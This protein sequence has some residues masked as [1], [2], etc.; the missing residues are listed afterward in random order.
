MDR[1]RFIALILR[2]PNDHPQVKKRMDIC[3]QV[4]E[5]KIDVEDI[6]I[7]GDSLLAKMFSTIYLGDFT[8]YHLA[9]RERIDPTPVEVIEWLKK[10][11]V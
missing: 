9:L 6:Q 5:K 11:L 7:K 8:S 2:D 10:Q 4:M 1:S 3:K